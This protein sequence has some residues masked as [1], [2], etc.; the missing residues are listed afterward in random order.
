MKLPAKTIYSR[1][2]PMYGTLIED[3]FCKITGPKD[4]FSNDWVEQG[5]IDT[6]AEHPEEMVEGGK[7]A[8]F[9]LDLRDNFQEFRLDYDSCGRDGMFDDTDTFVV[10]DREDVSKLISYLQNCI[11]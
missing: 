1:V 10:W 4:G 2:D 11:E 7:I 9:G 5:L 6:N 3:L 8:D